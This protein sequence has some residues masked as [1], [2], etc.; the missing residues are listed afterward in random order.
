MA[1]APKII[2]VEDLIH[3]LKYDVKKTDLGTHIEVRKYKQT[4]IRKNPDADP[5]VNIFDS[6]GELVESEE[7]TSLKA[8]RGT[9]GSFERRSVIQS[10]NNICGIASLNHSSWISFITLTFEDNVTDLTYCNNIFNEKMKYLRYHCQKMG[11]DFKYIGVPEFQKRGAIHYHIMT[12]IPVGCWLMPEREVKITKNT[13]KNA[14]QKLIKLRYYGFDWWPD[15]DTRIGLSEEKLKNHVVLGWASAFGL[16]DVD[17]K[18]SVT[19]YI[20][21]Y[22]W[23]NVDKVQE[24]EGSID[25]RLYNRIKVLRSRN[26]ITP[27]PEYIDTDKHYNETQLNWLDLSNTLISERFVESSSKY[28]PDVTI[29]KYIKNK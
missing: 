23:K 21:S 29:L 7:K 11:I 25:L 22:F 8:I 1:I 27:K 10:F 26:L 5:L 12:N 28:V 17:S 13:K 15:P 19:G 3:H 6:Y 2:T 18:F 16:S 24:G 14:T 20:A 4:M 9:L